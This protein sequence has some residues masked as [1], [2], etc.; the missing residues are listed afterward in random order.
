MDWL[1][2]THL[3]VDEVQDV[4]QHQLRMIELLITCKKCTVTLV[5][6]AFQSIFGFY[7]ANPNAIDH[8]SKLVEANKGEVH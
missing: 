1:V 2:P 6:D 8:L 7:G 5:G 3:F 4:N